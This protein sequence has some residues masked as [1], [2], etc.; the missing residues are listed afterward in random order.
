MNKSQ[1]D[2]QKMIAALKARG[3]SAVFHYVPL[4]QAPYWDGKYNEVDL[5]VTG[6]VAEGLLRLPMHYTLKD[7]DV[8]YVCN[9]IKDVVS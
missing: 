3:I 1:E 8:D 7:E 9:C 4:H 2:R 5:P 6:A